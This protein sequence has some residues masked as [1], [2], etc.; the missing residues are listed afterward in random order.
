MEIERVHIIQQELGCLSFSQGFVDSISSKEGT[1]LPLF[2]CPYILIIF[3]TIRSCFSK[4]ICLPDKLIRLWTFVYGRFPFVHN[5]EDQWGKQQ[6]IGL[7]LCEITDPARQPQI[8]LHC[9]FGS[10]STVLFSVQRGRKC[11]SFALYF[12]TLATEIFLFK[13]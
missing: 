8:S 2:T 5:A 9:S 13:R 6:L 10:R 12:I 4:E 11:C 7:W 1:G 3:S